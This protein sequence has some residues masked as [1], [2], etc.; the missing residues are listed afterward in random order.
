[1]PLFG[2]KRHQR[3]HFVWE[4]ILT[5]GRSATRLTVVFHPLLNNLNSNGV[6][7]FR[8]VTGTYGLKCV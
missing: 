5:K 1:M 6:L 2:R 8:E 3:S 7:D 4:F